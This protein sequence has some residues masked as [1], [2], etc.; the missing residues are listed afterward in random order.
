MP[1]K[2]NL[3]SMHTQHEYSGTMGDGGRSGWGRGWRQC[4][5]LSFFSNISLLFLSVEC[6]VV[7]AA[8]AAAARPHHPNYLLTVTANHNAH[9]AT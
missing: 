4:H 7:V 6:I 2:N 9:S 1:K 8:A 3:K 5:E